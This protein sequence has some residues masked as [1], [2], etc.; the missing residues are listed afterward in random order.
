M[1]SPQRAAITVLSA[2]LVLS[3][4]GCTLTGPQGTEAGLSKLAACAQDSLWSLDT[5]VLAESMK[6]AL[7]QQGVT[8]T[9]VTAEGGQIMT[10]GR[11]GSVA[12]QSDYTL[13][14]TTSPAADQVLTVTTTH[15]GT[16]RGASYINGE[17]AIPRNWDASK[18]VVKSTGDLNGTAVDPLPFGIPN[19][20]MNDT[21]GIEITCNGDTL[22][23][24][25]RGGT[26]I[27]TWK[28][29]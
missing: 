4:G 13:T 29:K 17:V 19:V 3:L 9:G 6:T 25:P 10:W 5:D 2:A 11:D 22:T 27:H 1:F 24:Q 21:V 26:V 28:R 8:A 7:A 16:A 12:L 23:T 14:I 18:T 15:K 20:D